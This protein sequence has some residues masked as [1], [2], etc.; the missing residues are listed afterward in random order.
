MATSVSLRVVPAVDTEG[1]ELNGTIVD[2]PIQ[3]VCD[4]CEAGLGRLPMTPP[5]AFPQAQSPEVLP[6]AA[7]GPTSHGPASSGPDSPGRAVPQTPII[8]PRVC[9]ATG[10]A[11]LYPIFYSQ[12]MEPPVTRQAITWH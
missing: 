8:I 2:H 11:L 6:A 9:P 3:H 10:D 5:L 7:G 4:K 12:P 1:H